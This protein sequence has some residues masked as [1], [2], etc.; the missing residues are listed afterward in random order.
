MASSK[1]LD[2]FEPMPLVTDI[3]KREWVGYKPVTPLQDNCCVEFQI[4]PSFKQYIDLKRTKLNLKYSLTKAD[5][6]LI[7]PAEV[8]RPSNGTPT[9]IAA[10]INM[11]LSSFFSQC[12]VSLQ[13][14]I[15]SSTIGSNY[16]YKAYIDALIDEAGKNEKT[17]LQTEGYLQQITGFDM[18]KLENSTLFFVTTQA[19]A[20]NGQMV[21]EGKIRS[22]ICSMEKLICNGV[23]ARFKFYQASDAFRIMAKGPEQYKI[24]ILDATLKVCLVTLSSEEMVRQ[25]QLFSRGPAIYEYMRSDI[26]SFQIAQGSYSATFENIYNG[27][28]PS[29]IVLGFIDSAAF[30][31][32]F[33]SNPLI[34]NHYN[35]NHLEVSVDGISV[36]KA[37]L[38]PNF[39]KED[40]A[41]AYSGLFKDNDEQALG[42]STYEFA[43]ECALFRFD[44][45]SYADPAVVRTVPHTGNLRITVRFA[46]PIPQ[47]VSC[48]SYAKIQDKFFVDQARNVYQG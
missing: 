11:Q 17:E 9:V 16:P 28:I 4:S 25:D 44:L 37:A 35:I 30:S 46:Q 14:L 33:H 22:D 45:Q 15:L 42:I 18:D 2:L 26:K 27:T 47:G 7:T 6:T 19:L 48:I 34:F 39:E 8:D 20:K 38:T 1:A 13:Q 29:E 10:P 24:N 23:S 43:K 36:P 31:G 32:S 3:V 5:G 40:F 21:V 41:D 12:D